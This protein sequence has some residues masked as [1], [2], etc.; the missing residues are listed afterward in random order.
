M[1]QTD[2]QVL[3]MMD[4]TRKICKIG[5]LLRKKNN[6]PVSLPLKELQF[7]G[8]FIHKQYQDLIKGELN[9]EYVNPFFHRGEFEKLYK[10]NTNFLKRFLSKWFKKYKEKKYHFLGE[11]WIETEKQGIKVALN[12][13]LD[14]YQIIQLEETKKRRQ[15]IQKNKRLEK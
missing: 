14:D 4:I 5:H 2:A 9:V 8:V 6:L 10:A 15:E 1:K 3:D 12:V 11:D 13:Y 7:E